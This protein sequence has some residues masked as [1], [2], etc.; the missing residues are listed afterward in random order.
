MEVHLA[1]MDL[2]NEVVYVEAWGDF[3]SQLAENCRIGDIVSIESA[4]VI[5]SQNPFSTSRLPCHLRPSISTP[6]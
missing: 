4:S 1:A 3:A 6:A 2:V 5:P